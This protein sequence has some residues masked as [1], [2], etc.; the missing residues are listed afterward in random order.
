MI[1]KRKNWEENKVMQ[2]FLSSDV[3]KNWV[4]EIRKQHRLL[5]QAEAAGKTHGGPSDGPLIPILCDRSWRRTW[6]LQRYSHKAEA[7]E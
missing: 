5:H 6:K 4:E 1:K 2:K 3:E 7:D